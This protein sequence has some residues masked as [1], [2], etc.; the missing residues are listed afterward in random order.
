M[1]FAV[2]S[3]FILPIFLFWDVIPKK[4]SSK[5]VESTLHMLIRS[6]KTVDWSTGLDYWTVWVVKG[7]HY[8]SMFRKSIR[9]CYVSKT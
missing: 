3:I 9:T 1:K 4:K 7:S 5:G 2:E 8:P 6:L